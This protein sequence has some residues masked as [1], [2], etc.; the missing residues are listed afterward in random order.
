V[1]SNKQKKKKDKNDLNAENAKMDN[2][3]YFKT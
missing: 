1:P 3:L 2:I